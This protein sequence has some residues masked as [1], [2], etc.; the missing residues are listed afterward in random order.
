L[1]DADVE[2]ARP[3]ATETH[4]SWH[5]FSEAVFAHVAEDLPTEEGGPEEHE[6]KEETPDAEATP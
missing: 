1:E 6:E 2:A 3:L 4:D 5:D